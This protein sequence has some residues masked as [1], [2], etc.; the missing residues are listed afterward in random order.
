MW[1]QELAQM[2][3]RMQLMRQG[4]RLRLEQLLPQQ[5]FSYLTQQNGMFSY[6]G[7]STTQ[8]QQLRDQFGIYLVGSGRL[9][10]AGLNQHNLEYV[11]HSLA[12]VMDNSEK[13]TA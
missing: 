3:E 8:V 11:A 10:I 4:L 1:Q 2:R 5:H 12:R 9:C 6:T 7:L 13:K